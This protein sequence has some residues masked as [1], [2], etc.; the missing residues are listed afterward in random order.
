MMR[1]QHG[2]GAAHP[3]PPQLD[4]L[5]ARAGGEDL[6]FPVLVAPPEGRESPHWTVRSDSQNRPLR[7]TIHYDAASGRELSR[8]T[9]A[10]KHPID[11]VVGYGVAWH[12]GQLF[13][14]INQLIG[15]LTALMLLTIAVSGFVLWRRRKPTGQLGAP[16]LPD[17]L[18]SPRALLVAA[19]LLAALLPLFALSLIAL[20]L[21]DRL[22]LPRLPG[23]A[24]WLGAT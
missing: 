7:V 14:W 24:R 16:P 18:P 5:V 9:F 2:H 8:E 20:W 11:R 6:A 4:T 12:E 19:A 22:A 17:R 1:H 21:F 23:A 10:G 3:A 15:L 13:G